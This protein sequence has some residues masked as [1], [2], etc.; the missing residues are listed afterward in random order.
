[1]DTQAWLDSAKKDMSKVQSYLEEQFSGLQMWKAN[2]KLLENVD[3]YIPSRWS[4]TKISNIANV[5]TMDAQTLRIEPREKSQVSSISK[6]IMDA[7]IWLNPQDMGEYV[8]IKVPAL[9]T[10][11]RKELTKIVAK[12]GEEAKVSVRNIRH[13]YLG[14]CK[15]S[16]EAKEISETEKWSFEK[17]IDEIAKDQNT[18]IDTEVNNKSAEIMKI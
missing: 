12:Y 17:R 8:I 14:K 16:F 18:K 4:E 5:T 1:M 9:T 3:V 2:T 6:W 10:E 13:D 7:N 15:K 11:R